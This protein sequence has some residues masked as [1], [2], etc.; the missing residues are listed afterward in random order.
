[1]HY[2]KF[3][4]PVGIIA[5]I[6]L[7]LKLISA[8]FSLLRPANVSKYLH[9][10]KVSW[11][12]ITG[13]TD[14]VGRALA[15]EFA[16]KGFNIII[17]GR[18][19]LKLSTVDKELQAKYPTIKTLIFPC[20]A[21]RNLSNSD[22]FIKNLKS[23]QD[24]HITV[25]VNNVGGMGCLPPSDLYK[26]LQA[27]TAE[28]VDTVINVNVGFM[29]QL[30]RIL[31]PF[32]DHS[33]DENNNRQPSL[34]LNMASLA[35]QGSPYVTVYTATKAFAETFTKSLEM[36]MQVEQKH[37]DVRAL[38]V[39]EVGSGSHVVDETFLTPSAANYASAAMKRLGSGEVV[40]AGCLGH[41]LAASMVA[42]IPRS[43]ARRM[44]IHTLLARKAKH[45]SRLEE[46]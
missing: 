6:F 12:I 35:A 46:N 20:D 41:W 39:G 16:K 22:P 4:A 13:A 1:M 33:G 11:A 3:F 9:K 23:L 8:T 10:G 37:I 21:S 27:Y 36:E 34:I 2:E 17:H 30:T 19:S 28:E 26:P 31:I 24:L 5:T 32:L 38:L 29:T 45:E 43:V 18:N 15:F 25:L 40:T 14:G 7:S 42:I 44:Y